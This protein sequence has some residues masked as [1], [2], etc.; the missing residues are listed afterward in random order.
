MAVCMLC[1]LKVSLHVLCYVSTGELLNIA[2]SQMENVH[3]HVLFKQW[4][5]TDSLLSADLYKFCI[6]ST[7]QSI[8]KQNRQDLV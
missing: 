7:L 6:D 2:L 8:I 3:Y 5:V 4:F 1:S